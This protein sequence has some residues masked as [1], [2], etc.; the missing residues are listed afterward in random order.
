[1]T[2]LKNSEIRE[3]VQRKRA[4][5]EE[6]RNQAEKV[7]GEARLQADQHMNKLNDEIE[8]LERHPR[9]ELEHLENGEIGLFGAIK[10]TWRDLTGQSKSHFS[11]NSKRKPYNY[12]PPPM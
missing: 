12:T 11:R 3:L 7:Q 4:Q 6:L 10:R 5:L 8:E 9:A 2:E 1:M